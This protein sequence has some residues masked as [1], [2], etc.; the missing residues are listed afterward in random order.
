MS[1]L[2]DPNRKFIGAIRNEYT[3]EFIS[4][5]RQTLDKGETLDCVYDDETSSIVYARCTD[6]NVRYYTGLLDG[7]IMAKNN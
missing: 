2:H 3:S 4:K 5:A 1:M 6:A 7:F